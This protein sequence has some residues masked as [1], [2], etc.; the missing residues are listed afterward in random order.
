MKNVEELKQKEAAIRT[1]E[2][3]LVS[4]LNRYE[5][6][7]R[8]TKAAEQAHEGNAQALSSSHGKSVGLEDKVASLKDEAVRLRAELTTVDGQVKGLR[9]TISTLQASI[10]GAQLGAVLELRQGEYRELRGELDALLERGAALTVEQGRAVNA[11]AVAGTALKEA[12]SQKRKALS[13]TDV[14]A[15]AELE[16]VALRQKSDVD[17]LLENIQAEKAKITAE[18]NRLRA[19]LDQA[20]KAL[21]CAQSEVLVESIQG[22]PGFAAAKG[23]IENAFAAWKCAGKGAN[24]S[25]FLTWVFKAEG[26]MNGIDSYRIKAL[27]VEMSRALGIV[28]DVR[29]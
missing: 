8:R 3:E 1:A 23:S 13:L 14:S 29:Q 16:S 7:L 15:A 26:L 6:L 9:G 5:D 20:E 4:L 24:F 10:A 18:Q 28:E 25:N 19:G 22:D 27:Q 17:G 11:Q 12:Q 21:W 2:S